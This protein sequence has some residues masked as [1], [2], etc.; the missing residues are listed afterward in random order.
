MSHLQGHSV[1]LRAV[2]PDETETIWRRFV[3][4]PL[5]LLMVVLGTFLLGYSGAF[6]PFRMSFFEAWAGGVFSG[7]E[8]FMLALPLIALVR[9][10]VARDTYVAPMDLM[11]SLFLLAIVT[12]VVPWIRMVLWEGGVRIPF[13]A[14]Y[15]P[16]FFIMV[17]AWRL[18]FQPSDVK[19]MAW[20][21]IPPIVFMCVEGLAIWITNPHVWGVLTG[22]RDGMLLALAVSGFLF[23]FAIR[24]DERW[25]RNLRRAL[26]LLAPFTIIV[27]V[28][29]MR[30]SFML[31]LLLTIPFVIGKLTREER[32]RLLIVSLVSLPFFIGAIG[33]F[34]FGNFADRMASVTN[35]GEEGS[36]AWRLIEYYN[37]THMIAERPVFGYPW[38][39]QFVNYTGIQ[40]PL[41]NSLVPHNVYMY[42]MY[43]GGVIGLAVLVWFLYKALKVNFRTIRLA[44]TPA[45]RFLAIWMTTGTLLI[46]TAGLTSPIVSSRL[47]I[48][49]PFMLVLTSFLPGALPEQTALRRRWSSWVTRIAL[50][51]KHR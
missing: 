40:L 9:R 10:T 33:V 21:L 5:G 12:V 6:E 32:R 45:F 51:G 26:I 20:M 11:P 35:P 38:G 29:S 27:F 48:L 42:V 4:D 18:I 39:V 16:F 30:R 37:V 7:I 15:M 47:V 17:A 41:I 46:V 22:W 34:G 19:L 25:Y 28:L 1:P 24:S 23:A 44:P 13:E 14:N 31:G 43:R 49:I 2:R 36:A 3:Y 8:V 50:A